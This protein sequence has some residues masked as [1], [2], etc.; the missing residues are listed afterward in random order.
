MTFHSRR[1]AVPGFFASKEKST[2]S[3]KG[4]EPPLQTAPTILPALSFF[5]S[6]FQPGIASNETPVTEAGN[7]ASMRI[8]GDCLS[9]GTVIVY[10]C[11]APDA[12]SFGEIRTCPKAVE[13]T[14]TTTKDAQ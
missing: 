14:A 11:V 4:I 2:D 7:V 5:S 3:A 8:V 13:A 12:D 1:P 9:V 10:F 6:I